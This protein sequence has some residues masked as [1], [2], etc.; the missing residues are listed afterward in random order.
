M[1][2]IIETDR[3]ILRPF[4]L[5]DIEDVLAFG[6]HPEVNRYTGDDSIDTKEAARNVIVNT[7]FSDYEKYGYGRLAT[8]YKADSKLIGFSGLKYL[9]EFDETDLGYRYLPEYWGKGIAT[10]AS[11]ALLDYGFNVLKL[12]KIIGTTLPDNVASS[13]VLEKV[14]MKLI[15]QEPY[16]DEGQLWN[17]FEIE[18]LR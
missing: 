11:I 9:P 12:K 1:N 3:L 17:W 4:T 10:E 14:G 18:D 5:D 8:I 7:W 16:G 2:T 6:S 13:R 15:R